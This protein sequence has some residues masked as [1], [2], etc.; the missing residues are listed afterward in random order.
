M[1]V[2][3]KNRIDRKYLAR[4]ICLLGFSI[5]VF[6]QLN[7]Q[8][9]IYPKPQNGNINNSISIINDTIICMKSPKGFGNKQEI[10]ASKTDS[11]SLEKEH[12]TI[13]YRYVSQSECDLSFLIIPDDKRDDYDFMLFE[14]VANSKDSLKILRNNKARVDEKIGGITGLRKA[15]KS[16]FVGEG[17]G[18][19]FSKPVTTKPGKVYYIL[20]DNVYDGGK[21]HKLILK[22]E[23]CK[24]V[25]HRK[26]F[27][28]SI[29]VKDKETDK[30]ILG[31]VQLLK[32]QY[33]NPPDTIISSSGLHFFSALD[34]GSYYKLQVEADS[35]LT[36]RTDFKV[37]AADTMKTVEVRLQ[38]IEIGKKIKLENIY[39]SGGSAVML[40]KSMNS[41]RYLVQV[42][43]DNPNLE[44]EI[45]GHVN[46]PLNSPKK[47]KES[48]YQGLSE[49]RAKAV[50]DYLIKRDITPNR[51]SYKGFGYSQML[52]PYAE[53]PEQ[54]EQ[55]RRVEILIIKM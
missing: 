31:K 8:Q 27:N 26:S 17:P 47:Q 11:T 18:N 34:S 38:K 45:Q 42:M 19:S 32:T 4:K 22:N 2:K 41:L 28:I 23:N 33:P 50:Y 55:N 7:A 43:Q 9:K 35:F 13:W 6:F 49:S 16:T 25:L 36:Y 29:L 52:F 53:T 14:V 20:I 10:S 5:F 15:V 39:F 44:I 37:Y 12:N 54:E 1:I 21:G 51:I 40:R 48:Y 3:A 46:Q 24:E 30:L